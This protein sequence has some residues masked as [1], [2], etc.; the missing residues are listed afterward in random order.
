MGAGKLTD[1]LVKKFSEGSLIIQDS[2]AAN[3][4][5]LT[6]EE[7]SGISVNWNNNFANHKNRGVFHHRRS[8]EWQPI[9]LSFTVK[10]SSFIAQGA[11][12]TPFEALQGIDGASGWTSAAV[13]SSDV[14]ATDIVWQLDD[15]VAA[16]AYQKVTFSDCAV[17][18]ISFQEGETEN[19]LAFTIEAS[20]Y[21]IAHSA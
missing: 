19:T 18:T 4:T 6:L 14:F 20:S 8:A 16:G 1:D 2:G 15:P 12:V 17:Q 5:T 21:A 9:E 11:D 3:S 7:G 13:N 10:Y